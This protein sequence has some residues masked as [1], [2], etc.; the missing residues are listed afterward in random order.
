VDDHDT[1]AAKI[2]EEF[3]SVM[4]QFTRVIARHIQSLNEDEEATM[5]QIR[6]L[7]FLLEEP[8]TT[9]ELAKK[10]KVTLQSA[11]VQVQGLVDRG[12]VE[13]LRDAKDRRQFL[14]QITPEGLERAQNAREQMTVFMAGFMKDLSEEE[15]NAGHIFLS[16]LKRVLVEDETPSRLIAA[17]RQAAITEDL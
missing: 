15:M 5:M 2:A 9:S 14:L 10:Q 7:F 6:A 16:A 11:S 1:G 13:R 12:W 8:I 3:L 4:P 17:L